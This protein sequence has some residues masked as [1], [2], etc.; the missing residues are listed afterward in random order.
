MNMERAVYREETVRWYKSGEEFK[1]PGVVADSYPE[2]FEML[3]GHPQ[4]I[5]APVRAP[6]REPTLA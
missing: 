6:R 4:V 1:T 2:A 3:Y 5:P